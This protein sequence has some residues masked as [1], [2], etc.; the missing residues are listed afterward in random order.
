MDTTL[1]PVRLTATTALTG[2]R[3]ASSSERARGSMVLG[4]WG[5]GVELTDGMVAR[6]TEMLAG[7]ARGA[8]AADITVAEAGAIAA[9]TPEADTR[10][11]DFTVRQRPAADSMVAQSIVAAASTAARPMV[12]ASTVVA[13]TA[14]D[15][16]KS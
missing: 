7:V 8:D 2:L 12:A 13:D 5:A 1:T 14:A 3:V 15:I 11:V 6:G 16:G 10:A 9:A 4:G